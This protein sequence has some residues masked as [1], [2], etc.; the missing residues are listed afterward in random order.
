MASSKHKFNFKQINLHHCKEATSLLRC[1]LDSG[2]T[3]VSLIQEPY[4]Y[5][6]KIRGLGNSGLVHYVSNS[7]GQVRACV[8]THK[9]VNAIMLQNF[10][11][12]D[13]VA[14][15]IRYNRNGTDYKLIVCSAYLAFDK[16]VLSQELVNITDYC[17]EN[18]I[19]CLIGCDANSHN[20]VWG[21]SDTNKRGEKLLEFILASDLSILNRGSR[22]TFI[23]RNREEVIDITLCSAAVELDVSDWRVSQ[24][25]SM[26][27]HQT[28]QFTLSADFYPTKPYRNPKK[29][30][31][32]TFRRNLSM[33]M[34]NWEVTVE[35]T[36]G[37][38]NAVSYVTS[39]LII[40]YEESCPFQK[41]KD[42]RESI[43]RNA[44]LKELKRNC[45]KAWN[46]RYRDFEAFRVSRKEYKKACRKFKR[47]SWKKFCESIE[48][49][50][51]SAR[52]HKIL[53]KDNEQQVCSLKLPSGEYTK[54][55]NS[56]LAFLLETHFP[57]CTVNDGFEDNE[58]EM[59]LSDVSES[60]IQKARYI[61][62][63]QRVRWA[64]KSF[65][66]FKSAGV[67]GIFPALL[68]EGIEV[69]IEPLHNIFT[70]CLALGYIPKKWREVRVTFIP[71]PGRVDYEQAKNHR[72]ISLSSF[73]LKT[74][75]RLVDLYIRDS[76][77][78]INPLHVNQHAYQ[79]GRSTM[80][81]IHK[82]TSLIE[83]TLNI[84]QVAL[85]VF[86]DIEGAF[87][88]ATFS[89][90][91]HA[92]AS[93]G[94]DEF[95]I[96]WIL[97]MLEKR[98]LTADFKG[99][100][101]KRQPVMGCPQGGVLSPLIWLLISD[102][103][104]GQLETANV[105]S[106]GFADDFVLLIR[107][108]FPDVIFDRMQQALK[109][110]EK[111][112]NS[113]SLSV[114][115]SKVGAMLFTKRRNL[116]TKPLLLF[117]KEISLVSEFKYLGLTLDCKLNWRSHLDNRIQ[118][119]CRTLGQC[120][121][122]LG[123]VWG[124]TPKVVHWLYTSVVRP[125]FS[126]GA[127]AWWVKAQDS[128]SASKLNHLQRLGLLAMTGAMSTT[129]TAALECLCGLQPLHIFVEAEARSELFRL[130]YWGHFKP[131]HISDN[132]YDCLWNKMVKFDSL[133]NAPN[134]CMISK[135]MTNRKFL[136]LFPSRENWVDSN[137]WLAADYIFYTDGSLC[138]DLAGSGVFS[139]CPEIQLVRS[140]GPCISV[141]QAEIL[142][143]LECAL[144]CLQKR[145]LNKRIFMCSDS[146]AALLA[147][148][149]FQF[150][151]KL[152]LEC[153]E[154]IQKLADGN[155]ITLVWVPGH[156]GV[157]GNENADALAREGSSKNPIAS[158]PAIPLPKSWFKANLNKWC[159]IAHF[160][161]WNESQTCKQTKLRI[162]K[163]LSESETK[164][165]RSLNKSDLR[166][167]V[168]VLT[169]HFY[170]NKHLHKM[171]LSPTSICERCGE[172]EDTAF[173]LV[174]ECPR[175]AQRRFKIFGDYYLSLRKFKVLGLW[176]IRSFIAGISL[177][178]HL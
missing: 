12:C 158:I 116:R 132:N 88:R 145:F 36:N 54:D 161:L 133:W 62:S 48:G 146:K 46:K 81:A 59:R 148:S 82:M 75:E 173:H 109:I 39:R 21:S 175:L 32:D 107:G 108:H 23:T 118:K 141:F 38:E 176:Q 166:S 78:S 130:K 53:S 156:S 95:I 44:N 139:D 112:T 35:N 56:L 20:E 174:C 2:Q 103:L 26:S 115:P 119:A 105:H 178:T 10:S 152:T 42:M 79:R 47:N 100:K 64:I 155:H 68:Q 8:Y 9:S 7:D 101:V 114:N 45:G 83:S 49:C 96:K 104:L 13:F 126:Y 111:F 172:Y 137:Q 65:S 84:K 52:I 71:K 40:S 135:V 147:L 117:G 87:D 169:G 164:R 3:G 143:L 1:G 14:V 171:K 73:L 163:P 17:V 61:A 123:R 154:L 58:N 15:Q 94:I 16:P 86:L 177:K 124:L 34:E 11:S 28:I 160:K 121:R 168:G 128:T 29:T 41:P 80:S 98:I 25:Y 37:I 120:R 72:G 129:P 69:L 33:F 150:S 43:W 63:Q 66:P 99:I 19:Q 131:K 60:I 31:W 22:P 162:S 89:S 165:L 138:D 51:A 122:A 170:F 106:L 91:T 159:R 76:I 18:N 167:L 70:S 74:L 136:I 67:D 157:I 153:R 97:S 113:V 90:F 24:E 149:S 4:F 92:A 85:A 102:A 140:L 93:K 27:D 5:K 77:L 142:A 125:V 127:V 55:E 30:N 134:D 151:S 6:G 144:F 110:V 57:G 50:S